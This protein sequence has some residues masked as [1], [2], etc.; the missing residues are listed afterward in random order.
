MRTILTALFMSL[1][2]QVWSDDL[3]KLESFM[4]GPDV[5]Q[6]T[7]I[8]IQKDATEL[9]DLVSGSPVKQISNAIFLFDTV[10]AEQ[11]WLVYEGGHG[12]FAN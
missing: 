6:L 9:V 12:F 2:T 4:C 7:P 10:E 3:L 8:L 1:A 5:G 11:K